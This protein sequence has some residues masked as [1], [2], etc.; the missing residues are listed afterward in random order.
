MYKYL[1]KY[2][3][4]STFHFKYA[5]ISKYISINSFLIDFMHF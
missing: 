2:Q 4:P 5:K 1:N 3:I